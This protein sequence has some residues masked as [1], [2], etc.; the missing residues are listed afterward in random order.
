MNIIRIIPPPE[1]HHREP[2]RYLEDAGQVSQVKEVVESN[3]RGYEVPCHHRMDSDCCL[4][5]CGAAPE[6][7]WTEHLLLEVET[8]DVAVDGVQSIQGWKVECKH[9]EMSLER[10][11]QRRVVN[12]RNYN[13]TNRFSPKSLIFVILSMLIAI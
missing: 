11:T 1:M 7:W 10:K 3:S 12:N 13:G 8:K 5:Q 6:N 9:C 2:S 4:Y